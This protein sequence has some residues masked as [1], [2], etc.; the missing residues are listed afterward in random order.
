MK[1]PKAGKDRRGQHD[2]TISRLDSL[3]D[4]PRWRTWNRDAALIG[5][6]ILEPVDRT[7]RCKN[8]E[9]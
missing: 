3:H 6:T 8:L 7:D 4:V 2:R 1:R 5:H 9:I